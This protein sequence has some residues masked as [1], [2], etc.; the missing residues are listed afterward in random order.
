MPRSRK[1]ASKPAGSKEM[2]RQCYM[3]GMEAMLRS[4]GIRNFTAHEL[5]PAGREHGGA[6]LLPPPAKLW[7]NII[8]TVK[9]AQ[10]ARDHFGEP[11]YVNSGYRN[12]T[13]NRAV[14]STSRRHVEFF[15]M[16][17]RFERIS[18]KEL[19]DWLNAHPLSDIMGL[20]LYPSFVHMDAMGQ[21]ARWGE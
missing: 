14:G 9:I 4:H 5:C 6:R 15:A 13:Y 19:F 7:P 20:G 11:L 1:S 18:T 3:E 10:E 16:D 2:T 17:V 8:P 12:A 21:R